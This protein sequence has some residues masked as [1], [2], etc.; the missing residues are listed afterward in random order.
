MSAQDQ[1]HEEVGQ[2]M[3]ALGPKPMR[4]GIPLSGPST[5][6]DRITALEMDIQAL[7]RGLLWAGGQIDYLNRKINDLKG[8]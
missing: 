7:Y 6:E 3:S 2:L 8:A 4:Q 5:P 1:L